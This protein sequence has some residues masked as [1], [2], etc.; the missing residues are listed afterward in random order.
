[1]QTVST[2]QVADEVV[3]LKLVPGE[4]AFFQKE[5]EDRKVKER[6]HIASCQEEHY[7]H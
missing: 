2:F 7:E 1:M 4:T 3:R 6:S 5:A